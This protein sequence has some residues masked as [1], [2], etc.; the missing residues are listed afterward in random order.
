MKKIALVRTNVIVCTIIVVGY[1]I[2]SFISY[3][4][5]QGL[6]QQETENVS[7]LTS[8]GISHE[9]DSIFARPVSVSLTMGN[10]SLLKQCLMEE[11]ERKNDADYI[12][13]LRNYLGTYKDKYGYDSAFLV[14]AETDRYYNFN[15]ID[16]ILYPDNPENT[17]YF[18][19]MDSSQEYYI[20]IDN[21]EAANADNEITVF[22]NCKIRDR[23]GKLLGIVGVG[24]RVNYIQKIF[25]DYEEQYQI[26]AYLVDKD[27]NIQIS[28]S[29][30]GYDKKDLFSFSGY[31]QL[32][33]QILQE[34]KE[35][36]TC[37]YADGGQKGYLVTQYIPI[38]G[39]HLIV[40]KDTTAAQQRQRLE[41]LGGV[42]III[43]VIILVLLIITNIIRK[44]NKEVVRMAV[45]KE[46]RHSTRFQMETE[47]I[48]ENIY[49]VDIT[50]NRAASESTE[51]YFRSLGVPEDT[52]YDKALHII[53]EK[54]IK[55]EYRELYI[56][57]FSPENIQKAYVEGKESLRCDFQIS[58]D[59]GASYY[60]MRITARIFYWDEDKSVRIFVYRQNVDEEIKHEQ[61]LMSRMERDSLTGLYNKAATQ[62]HIQRLLAEEPDRK[63]AF[64]I[65]DIDN[66]KQVNDSFG[67]AFGDMVITGFGELLKKQFRSNDIVGRIGGDEFVVFLEIP[68]DKWATDK[69]ES[70]V[71]ELHH[72]FSDGTMH[73]RT[74]ASI[75]IA[76]APKDGNSF[77]ILYRN[78]D[79]AL[80]RAK[81]KGKCVFCISKED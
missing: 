65:I 48:Y 52:P 34:R 17:W 1:V 72:E 3:H 80:Y 70:L 29:Q 56:D 47:K 61:K 59:E 36:Y 8:E 78:S 24:F 58:N 39:W 60:W 46:K 45:E 9:I 6:F 16:R 33:D 13:T 26:K 43:L 21:D 37:W 19:Q 63:H 2:T 69:A 53:A 55:E 11:A 79:K 32:K 38:L 4:S 62:H 81:E 30:T 77:E 28:T 76:F 68:S 25:G 54:Q 64:Y 12:E 14:S 66:F 57:T 75:G 35:S 67:H 18:T 40:E 27:G 50:H 10:D 41:F 73:W 71:R 44:Y 51:E 15:G 31:S 5:N 74:S 42:L 7:N 23:E 20:N 22:I 49:E